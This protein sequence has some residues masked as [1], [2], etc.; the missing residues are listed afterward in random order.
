MSR[1]EEHE[2]EI[3]TRAA[4]LT[5]S[6]LRAALKAAILEIIR[7]FRSEA[8]EW[9]ITSWWVRVLIGV[10]TVLGL[11]GYFIKAHT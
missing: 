5:I 2:D 8:I 1:Q 11:L 10:L 3:V 9:A 6:H 7:E 4:A